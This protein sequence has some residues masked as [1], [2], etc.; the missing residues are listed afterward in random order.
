MFRMTDAFPDLHMEE[1]RRLI[2]AC[3]S[4]GFF[5]VNIGANDGVH[6]DPVYPFIAQYGWRG[7]AVEPDP[8]VF[9]E[10]RRNYRQFSSV[11]VEHAA[12]AATPRLLYRIGNGPF[13]RAQWMSQFT[14]ASPGRVREVIG[15]VRKY[16]LLGPVPSDLEDYV[17]PIDVPCLTFQQLVDRHEIERIDYLNIDV[18]G[19]DLEVLEQVDLDRF[20]NRL[21][22][23]EMDPERDSRAAEVEQRLQRLG[24][25]AHKGL[26]LFSVFYLRE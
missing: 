11:A 13:E 7:V 24:Y 16:G 9:E 2:E 1:V 22:C 10:L 12:I 17:E 19:D 15:L 14:A 6:N 25:R 21:L 26:M 23:I 20:R 8:D 4:P 18:E 5:F 3:M